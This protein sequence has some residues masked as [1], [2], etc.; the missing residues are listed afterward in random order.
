[1]KKKGLKLMKSEKLGKVLTVQWRL[2]SL[3]DWLPTALWTQGADGNKL[4][5]VQ[6]DNK[7]RG[8]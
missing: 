5:T 7:S 3:V 4:Y 1:M 6:N 2:L 8:L